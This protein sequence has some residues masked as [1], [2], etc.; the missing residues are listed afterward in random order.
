MYGPTRF[1]GDLRNLGYVISEVSTPDGHLFA[2]M[3]VFEISLGRFAGRTIGLALQATPDFP[4]TVPSAIHVRA[5]PH[6]YDVSD[7]VPNVRN[8][9][10]SG[11]GGEWRYWSHNFGWKGDRAAR[12]LM[13]QVNGVFLHAA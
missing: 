1:F 6:L 10:A 2:V 13:S 9:T 7:S 3:Q 11:L 12:N 8:I 5:A 4:K